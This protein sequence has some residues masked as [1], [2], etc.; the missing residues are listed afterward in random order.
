GKTYRYKYDGLRK[1]R[2]LRGNVISQ[3]TRQINLKIV[4][5]GKRPLGVIFG[6]EEEAPDN[7]SSGEEE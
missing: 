6:V 1:R 5:A 7:Q 2:N 3:E 4:E